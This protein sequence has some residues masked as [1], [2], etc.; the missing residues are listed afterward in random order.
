MMFRLNLKKFIVIS[1]AIHVFVLSVFV[2]VIPGSV[3]RI[4]PYTRIDFLGAVFKKTVFDLMM[5]ESG[6]NDKSTD[7]RTAMLYIPAVLD[8][9]I[10]GKIG[11]VDD[12]GTSCEIEVITAGSFKNEKPVPD[13]MLREKITVERGKR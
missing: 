12:V 1:L 7:V 10:P 11:P 6:G 4:R 8:A 9:G 2:I 13:I 3:G 5:G